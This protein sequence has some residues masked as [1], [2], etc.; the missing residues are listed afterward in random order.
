M[1]EYYDIFDELSAANQMGRRAI[2]IFELTNSSAFS[3]CRVTSGEVRT[4]V[5][6]SGMDPQLYP[7]QKV[8]ESD[9]LTGIDWWIDVRCA[10]ENWAV[11]LAREFLGK[12][13][14]APGEVNLHSCIVE[15]FLSNMSDEIDSLSR[16]R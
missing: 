10:A 12:H 4:H 13:D 8:S 7:P 15:S 14:E 1:K 6:Q 5:A 9:Y 16:I 11:E 3:W 2:V